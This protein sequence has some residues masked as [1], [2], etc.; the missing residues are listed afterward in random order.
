MGA[1]PPRPRPT[2]PSTAPLSAPAPPAQAAPDTSPGPDTS[3]PPDVTPPEPFANEQVAAPTSPTVPSQSKAP[4]PTAPPPSDPNLDDPGASP[5]TEVLLPS[6]VN[7][8]T[9]LTGA[10]VIASGLLLALRRRRRRAGTPLPRFETTEVE[11]SLIGAADVPL[12]RW[13]GQELA[14]LAEQIAGRRP[15]ANPIAVEFS[16]ATGV[17]ILWDRPFGDAPG[18]WEAVPGDWS[19]RTPYDP[20][21]EI[22]AALRP[23][24]IAG[25]VTVGHY[26][27]RELM[28]NLEAV[29][30]LAVVGEP[31]PTADFLRA[32]IVELG[33]SDDTSDAY[34]AATPGLI[35]PDLIDHL[36]R[37]TVLNPEQALS[38]LTAAANTATT[39]LNGIDVDTTFAYRTYTAPVLPLEVTVVVAS[40]EDEIIVSALTEH[41]Q[42]H[43]GVAAVLAGEVRTPAL[44]S[45]SSQTERGGSNRSASPSPP[46]GSRKQP[47]WPSRNFWTPP[48]STRQMTCRSRAAT[49]K[50]RSTN[51]T[52]RTW[53]RSD[54]PT[55]HST[56][57]PPLPRRINLTAS[58]QRLLVRGPTP[59]WLWSERCPSHEC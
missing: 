30:T 44:P 56:T 54:T 28:I 50:T 42:P 57:D 8:V 59:T 20:D 33:A 27:G 6:L 37:L 12:V 3:L 9:G 14:M 47:G 38:Q 13:V 18:P 31:E 17:E 19:W 24:P 45:P 7:P 51:P 11:R 53:R 25:L 48:Q 10:A 15:M 41:A 46:P 40:A 2:A 32:V 4:P 43:R 52:T 22:P 49:T 5:E 36:P 39:A 34:V 1:H 16:E 29:G 55:R 35:A 58:S 23:S 21:A 26:D